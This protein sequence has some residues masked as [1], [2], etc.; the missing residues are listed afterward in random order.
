MLN[1]KTVTF[2][3]EIVTQYYTFAHYYSHT[4]LHVVGK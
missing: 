1:C 3:I 4:L 2:S